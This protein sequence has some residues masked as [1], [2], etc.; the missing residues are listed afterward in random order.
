MLHFTYLSDIHYEVRRYIDRRLLPAK[1]FEKFGNYL[2]MFYDD[3]SYHFVLASNFK[4]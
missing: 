2:D 4:N 3:C 1:K